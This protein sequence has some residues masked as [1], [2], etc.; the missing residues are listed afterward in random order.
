[1]RDPGE[2]LVVIEGSCAV[3]QCVA[4]DIEEVGAGREGEI[5]E[6]G[7]EAYV[8]MGREWAQ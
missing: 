1:M 3:A 8:M 4:V 6:G 7:E 5:G 2:G